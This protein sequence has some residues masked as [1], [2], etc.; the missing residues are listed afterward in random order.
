MVWADLARR[1]IVQWMAARPQITQTDVAQALQKDQT[2]VSRYKLGKQQ[3]DL[4]DLAAMARA[5]GHTLTELLDLQPD[6]TEQRL[7]D[8]FRSLPVH[9]RALA[10]QTLEMMLPDPPKQKKR[11][12]GTP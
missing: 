2:W 11:S 8:A 1:R 9:K 5:Y 7:L 4:D 6:A 12:R 3:A 10:V